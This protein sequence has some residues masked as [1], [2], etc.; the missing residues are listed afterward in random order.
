MTQ[1][2]AATA[3]EHAQ[4]IAQPAAR[5]LPSASVRRRR[6][7]PRDEYLAN[8]H[9]YMASPQWAATRAAVLERAGGRCEWCGREAVQAHHLTYARLGREHWGDL[10]ALCFK[11]HDDQHDRWPH[12]EVRGQ[13]IIVW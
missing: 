7:V 1:L 11:C 4:P 3:P 8:Y 9:A 13:R 5:D 12:V 10:V 2:L 6:W